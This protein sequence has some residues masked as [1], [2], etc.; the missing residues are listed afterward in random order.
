MAIIRGPDARSEATDRRRKEYC[1]LEECKAQRILPYL[2]PLL[3]DHDSP[4]YE[5]LLT[6]P[7]IA[8]INHD[9]LQYPC[10]MERSMKYE[11]EFERRNLRT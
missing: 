2:R 5:K 8:L 3:W 1:G 10:L 4:Q 6:S 11:K 9:S 7:F